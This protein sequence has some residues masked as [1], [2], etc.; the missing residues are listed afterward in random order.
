[1]PGEANFGGVVP[2]LSELRPSRIPTLRPLIRIMIARIMSVI[3][4]KISKAAGA[5]SSAASA[6]LDPVK[7]MS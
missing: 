1:M 6:R 7:V 2:V 3:K 5:Q 4:A